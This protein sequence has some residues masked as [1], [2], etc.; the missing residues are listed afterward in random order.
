[1][2]QARNILAAV[3]KFPQDEPVLAR[4]AEIARAHQARLTIVHVID[5]FS[6]LELAPADLSLIQYQVQLGARKSVEAALARQDVDVPEIDI[7][8]EIGSPYQRVIELTNEINADLVVMRAHQGDSILAKIIGSTTDRVIRT[9]CAPVLVVKRPVTRAY[10]GVVV[11]IEMSDDSAAVVPFVAALLPLAGLHLIHVVQILP[12]F[13][14]AMLRAGSGQAGIAAHRVALIR[15][16][17]AR[18][19]D[20][21]KRLTNRPIR[22]AT[23][24]VVGDPATS[25]VRATWSPQADLIVLDRRRTGRIRRALLGSVTQRVLRTAACDVLIFCPVPQQAR[26]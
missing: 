11:G 14:A 5:D 24:V 21:S 1:M 22:S 4:A 17:K 26:E 2:S 19:R 16:A 3:G 25:L 7:R 9:T 12:P 8:I 23:R 20:M 10:H 18:M 13:E 6:G 15:K